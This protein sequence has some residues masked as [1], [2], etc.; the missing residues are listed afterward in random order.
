MSYTE[1]HTGKL[2]KLNLKDY[3]AKME[4][5]ISKDIFDLYENGM[6]LGVLFNKLKYKTD[7]IEK[8]YLVD[9][10]LY[11][12]VECKE[13]EDSDYLSIFNKNSDGTIDFTVRFYNGG[14]CLDEMIEEGISEL[15]KK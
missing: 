10:D 11:E 15:N 7:E 5:L 14:T 8:Y 1:Q 6:T 4:F 9:G 13:F 12:L 2:K 3:Q